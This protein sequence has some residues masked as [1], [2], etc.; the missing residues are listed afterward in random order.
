VKNDLA[1]TRRKPVMATES[2]NYGEGQSAVAFD[3]TAFSP[4]A[5]SQNWVS[6]VS[7]ATWSLRLWVDQAQRLYPGD[8]CRQRQ[9]VL[10]H[11]AIAVRHARSPERVA[12]LWALA[13]QVALRCRQ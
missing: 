11:I 7:Q 9:A 5:A 12:W 4:A 6:R 8:C 1:P 3:D 10:A 13:R 2:S